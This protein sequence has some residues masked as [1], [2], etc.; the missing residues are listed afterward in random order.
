MLLGM[1]SVVQ[2]PVTLKVRTGKDEQQPILHKFISQL[3]ECNASAI[4]IHGRSRQQRYSKLADW[5]YIEKCCQL[6]Q[7]KIPVI[8]L[9]FTSH[10]HLPGNGDIYSFEDYRRI[11]AETNVSSVMLA[12]GAII[13]PWIFTEIKENRHWGKCTF[14]LMFQLDISSNERLEIISDFCKHG[15]EHWGSDDKGLETTRRFLLEWMS[16]LHRYVP[17]GLLEHVTPDQ[18]RMNARSIAS[19]IGRDDKESM[20]AS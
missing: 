6:L 7:G 16:F 10:S 5:N 14:A 18:I 20:L 4:T 12:R 17:V 2:V 19:F 3:P 15:L 11:K 8:G 9:N 1:S 13:K